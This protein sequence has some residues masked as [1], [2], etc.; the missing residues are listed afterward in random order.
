MSGDRGGC[1]GIGKGDWG[2]GEG[3]LSG[4]DGL[5]GVPLVCQFVVLVGD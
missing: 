5:V 3:R 4:R 1:P 2:L